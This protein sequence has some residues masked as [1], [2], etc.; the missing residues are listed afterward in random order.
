MCIRDSIVGVATAI[1][2]GGAGAVFWLW[3][4]ALLGMMT[5]S[6]THLDVYKR[7]TDTSGG[8]GNYGYAHYIT[9]LNKKYSLFAR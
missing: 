8:T 1:S 3:I 2:S 9:P 5:V 7:Q 6:Y 4:S